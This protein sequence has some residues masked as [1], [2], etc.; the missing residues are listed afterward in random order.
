MYVC[1]LQ[2][3]ASRHHQT[4]LAR[5][6]AVPAGQSGT[7]PSHPVPYPN[8]LCQSAAVRPHPSLDGEAPGI[9]GNQRTAGTGSRTSTTVR[10]GQV[11]MK[12][13]YTT[14]K[15]LNPGTWK[16]S[17]PGAPLIDNGMEQTGPNKSTATA[18]IRAVAP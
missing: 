10:E 7:L 3:Q 8:P 12:P 6:K 16:E 11:A 1:P 4:A 15:V 13:V 5:T 9:S 17:T 2:G 18:K 14:D